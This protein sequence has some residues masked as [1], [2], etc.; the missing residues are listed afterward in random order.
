MSATRFRIDG[1]I[2]AAM[3]IG[4]KAGD[5]RPDGMGMQS[6]LSGALVF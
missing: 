3:A 1:A 2:A 5:E 4:C 6:F